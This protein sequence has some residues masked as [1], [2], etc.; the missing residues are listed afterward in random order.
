MAPQPLKV[1]PHGP[2]NGPHNIA[3]SDPVRAG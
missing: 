3:D 2:E 1:A